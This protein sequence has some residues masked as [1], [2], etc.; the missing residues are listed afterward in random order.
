VPCRQVSDYPASTQ[1]LQILGERTWLIRQN[2]RGQGR[3]APRSDYR[4]LS[5]AAGRQVLESAYELTCKT[6]LNG[7]GQDDQ[8]LIVLNSERQLVGSA[9]RW[10]AINSN[11]AGPSVGVHLIAC[12]LRG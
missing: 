8:Q 2:G 6:Y 3:R 9:Y 12:P 1:G 11:V 4:P 5:R 7:G 10:V